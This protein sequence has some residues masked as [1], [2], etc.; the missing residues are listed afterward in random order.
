MLTLILGGAR[1]GKSTRALSLADGR[2]LFVATAEALDDEMAARIAAHKAERPAGWDTL[3]EPRQI[4]RVLRAKGGGYD[5]VIVDCLTLWVGNLIEGGGTP[6]EWVA[7]LLAAYQAHR[8]NWVVISNEVGL[9]IVPDN[10]L[11]RRY[12][13]VLGVVNQ[14]VAEAADRVTLMVAGIAVQIKGETS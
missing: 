2:V 11:A 6:A 7:P 3:E 12:R 5:T 8:S 1:S 13:D 14:L 10:P 9:G 4:A